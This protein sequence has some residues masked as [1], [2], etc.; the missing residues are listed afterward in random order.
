MTIK[1]STLENLIGY[2][3]IMNGTYNIYNDNK[4]EEKKYCELT[5]QEKQHLRVKHINY[6][7]LKDIYYIY[8]I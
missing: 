8:C 4:I 6:L 2:K 3:C 5:D 7:P 1:L